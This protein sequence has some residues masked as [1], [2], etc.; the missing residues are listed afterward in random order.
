MST[1]LSPL[2]APLLSSAAMR[3]VCDDAAY[4]QHMLD[5]ES[6]LARAE[7]A[8][9]VIPGPAAPVISKA[10]VAEHF[11]IPALANAGA[12]AG[13][14]AIP[15]VKMLTSHVAK[16]DTDAARYVHWGATSQDVIDTATVLQ[17][18][19]AIDA[20]LGDL[21]RAIAGFAKLAKQH[22]ET[23]VVARTLLQHALPMPFG[24][25]L[26]EYA[27]ALHRSRM[28]L[29]RLR[30]E[31]LV[32]QFGGAAGTLA[33]LGDR[34][35]K[36]AEQLARELSLPLPDAPWHTHRDR[37]AEAASVFAILAGTCGKI[38]RDVSLMMQT[39]VAEA[40]EPAGEGRGGSSTLPH[41]RNPVAAASALAAATMAP[42]LAATIF[43]AQVQDHERSAGPWHAE[44]PTLPTLLLVTSGALAAVVEI[45]E[46]LEVD[47]A[48]MRANLDSTRGLVMAEAVS[49]A[50]AEN[51]GKNDAHRI[52]EA[53]SRKAIETRQHLRD[54]LLAD[55]RVTAHI[56]ADKLEGL[57]DP[58]K[59]QGMSQALIDRLLA[60]LDHE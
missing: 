33:A 6:A 60:P 42:N 54:I 25:K 11:D 34:G 30:A 56:S 41:K 14:L 2:L 21:D 19:A 26:A 38:A 4:V 32:L 7:A 29:K 1:F 8:T 47:A 52:V 17:L 28:R 51:V 24:L 43:A 15:L 45:A 31:A 55:A 13:N 53:A 49:M 10:C 9:A 40:F 36:V 23:A 3:A 18:R 46:G 39:D 5:F 57:F 20:L 59:Y 37:I 44:W 48:R 35:L 50:L 16:V 27:S 12:V 58:M 22:R